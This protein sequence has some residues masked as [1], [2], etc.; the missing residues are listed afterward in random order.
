MGAHAT[1]DAAWSES[2]RR[3]PS[4]TLPSAVAD[5]EGGSTGP[6]PLGGGEPGALG[7]GVAKA[8]E[9]YGNLWN[10]LPPG[11]NGNVTALDVAPLGG[12]TTATPTTPAHFADQLEMYDALTKHEPA[13]I[14]PGPT[15]TG[16]TS[17]RTSPP[18]PS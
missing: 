1:F 17:V 12:S 9:S 8:G 15:S 18:P 5:G 4:S 13:S 14:T 16:S 2:S 10:I 3:A 6:G 11:S 7:V